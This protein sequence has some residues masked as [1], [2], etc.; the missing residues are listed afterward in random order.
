MSIDNIENCF[1]ET[2]Y[3][4]ERLLSTCQ[5]TSTFMFKLC[6]TLI[7]S[8]CL[9]FAKFKFVTLSGSP[10]MMSVWL[11]GNRLGEDEGVWVWSTGETVTGNLW[12]A[13]GGGQGNFVRNMPNQLL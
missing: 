9:Q 8:L 3:L 10:E 2:S 13:T 1:K 12:G 6:F 5:P 11:G 4:K 7:S